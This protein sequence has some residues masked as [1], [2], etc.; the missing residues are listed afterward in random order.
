MRNSTSGRGFTLIE[1]LVVIAIIAVLIALLL[2]AV[3]AAREAARRSQCVNNLKQIGLALHNYHQV[4]D[5]FPLGVSLNLYTPTQYKAKNSWGHFGMLLPFAEQ[6]AIYNAANF[7]LGVEEGTDSLAFWTNLTATGAQIKNFVCPSDPN[8]GAG[9]S[10]TVKGIVFPDNN[11][12][13]YFA[14]VGTTTYLTLASGSADTIQ[15]W[16]VPS[17]GLF[18]FQKSYGVRDCIDGTSNTIA[19]SE[20]LVGAGEQQG[21]TEGHRGDQRQRSVG[22]D[23][24][25]RL[26]DQPH[27]AQYRPCGL[28]H[29]LAERHEPGQPARPKLGPRGDGADALQYGRAAQ[30]EATRLGPLQ[31]HQL[32]RGGRLQQRSQ[33]SFRRRQ[34][35]VDRRQRQVHKGLDRPEHLV[36]ARHPGQRRGPR[37]Q[38]LLIAGHP[39]PIGLRLSPSGVV[40]APKPGATRFLQSCELAHFAG[41][42]GL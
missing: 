36:G 39:L 20:S 23:G 19:Y 13:N 29:R 35:P 14:S 25:G 17:T 42:Y 11:S 30:L 10:A 16:N 1:L 3:Q 24:D 8:G 18:T 38:Q 33:L 41:L 12:S 6:Q 34:H 28:R 7:S 21:E 40:L 37:R 22:G 5:A 26:V 32:L 4:H 2:P 15:Q 9:A 31:Q 27:H